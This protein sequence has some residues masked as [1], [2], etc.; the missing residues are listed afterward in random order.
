MKITDEVREFMRDCQKKSAIS[1]W[2]KLNKQQRSQ[3]IKL[4]R[5][6]A[7]KKVKNKC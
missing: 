6:K 1:R 2:N 4:V 7:F 3:A 5:S